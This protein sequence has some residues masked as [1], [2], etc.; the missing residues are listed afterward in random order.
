MGSLWIK[1]F[2][3][4]FSV[5]QYAEQSSARILLGDYQALEERRTKREEPRKKNEDITAEKVTTRLMARNTFLKNHII[6][7]YNGILKTSIFR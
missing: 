2:G 4:E 1:E 3:H 7:K 6:K 5:G